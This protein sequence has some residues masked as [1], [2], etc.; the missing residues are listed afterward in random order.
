M[1]SVLYRAWPQTLNIFYYLWWYDAILNI[2][3]TE[4]SGAK[5]QKSG[6]ESYT[7]RLKCFD[8]L[9]CYLSKIRQ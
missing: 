1:K 4:I 9:K 8:N 3:H 6:K 2:N 7:I 5:E